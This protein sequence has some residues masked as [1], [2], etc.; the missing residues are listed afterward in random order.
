MNSRAQV[1]SEYLSIVSVM[2]VFLA[3]L[4]GISLTTYYGTINAQQLTN[5]LQEL[6]AVANN[7]FALGNGN[8]LKATISL[9]ENIES[10][11]VTGNKVGFTVNGVENFIYMDMNVHG[12]LPTSSGM[13]YIKVKAVDGNVFF[14]EI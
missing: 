1:A 6:E 4:V 2:L 3:I 12:S 10:S 5:S 9:P 14:K 13:H 7:V 8:S 11:N